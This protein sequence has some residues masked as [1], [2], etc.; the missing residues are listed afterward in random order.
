[1]LDERKRFILQAV[2]DDYIH[3]AEPVGSK[4]LAGRHGLN[5][6]PAT[7]RHEMASLEEMGYLKQPHTSAGRIPTDKGYRYYVDTLKDSLVLSS[8]VK[9]DFSRKL[10]GIRARELEDLMR[11]VP[12]LLANLTCYVSLILGPPRKRR[13]YFWGVSNLI[14]QPEFEDVHRMEFLFE[15]LESEAALTNLLAEAVSDREVQVRIGSENKSEGLQELSLVLVGY[16]MRDEPLGTVG[17]LGPTRMDYVRIIP[18]V[19][20]TARSLSRLLESVHG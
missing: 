8:M 20:Y 5:V 7:I 9:R 6:S 16:G 13:V 17:I 1:M 15:L 4:N 18:V 12:H 2:V 14:H 11:E 10:A 19:D 3:T